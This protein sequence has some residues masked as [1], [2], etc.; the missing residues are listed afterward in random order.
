MITN[1]IINTDLLT[2]HNLIDIFSYY[3]MRHEH[4]RN[5]RDFDLC[6]GTSF[7]VNISTIIILL[8][9]YFKFSEIDFIFEDGFLIK[10]HF[11]SAADS[12]RPNLSN[13]GHF[14]PK[15]LKIPAR[16]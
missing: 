3:L 13:W 16:T 10:A 5:S 1:Q 6:P 14:L 4:I 11:R 8:L 9:Y 7:F 15:I 2:Y 12:E